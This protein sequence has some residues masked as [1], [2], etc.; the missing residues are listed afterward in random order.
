M[1][2]LQWG[3]VGG[4]RSGA[5][6]CKCNAFPA[7][8]APLESSPSPHRSGLPSPARTATHEVSRPNHGTRLPL[9]LLVLV[10]PNTT[11]AS[12]LVSVSPLEHSS[13]SSLAQP[14]QS[15]RQHLAS[16]HPYEYQVH[17]DKS[18]FTNTQASLSR[19]HD[20][21]R[22]TTAVASLLHPVGDWATVFAPCS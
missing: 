17:F 4:A 14:P 1:S 7:I 9:L 12:S 5:S 8:F 16:F 22:S 11:A 19:C 10:R 20:R 21:T 18:I 15:R 3:D 2:G 13:S 6:S